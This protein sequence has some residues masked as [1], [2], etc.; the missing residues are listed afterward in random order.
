MNIPEDLE[1]EAHCRP[2][3][4]KCTSLLSPKSEGNFVYFFKGHPDVGR[5]LSLQQEVH[6]MMPYCVHNG[7]IL[8]ELS[9]LSK[10]ETSCCSFFS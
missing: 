1:Y 6:R 5:L 10:M 2:I 9:S 4:S 3:L 8:V 7:L